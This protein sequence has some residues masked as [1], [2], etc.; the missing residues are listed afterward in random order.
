[1]RRR[2]LQDIT[3]MRIHVALTREKVR[4]S[5]DIDS[6]KPVS[7]RSILD[8]RIDLAESIVYLCTL[9]AHQPRAIDRYIHYFGET[10]SIGGVAP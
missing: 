9:I 10:R 8:R 3:G 7:A 5:P 2:A 6:H 4:N 1:M